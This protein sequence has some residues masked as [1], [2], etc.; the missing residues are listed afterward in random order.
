MMRIRKN[1]LDMT[2]H[3]WDVFNNAINE[4]VESGKW[5]AI[6]MYHADRVHGH[7]MYGS[8]AGP[9]GYDRFLHWHRAYL[10]ECEDALREIDPAITIPYWEWLASERIPPGLNHIP[11]RGVSHNPGIVNFTDQRE[12]SRIMRQATF[13]LFVRDLENNPH[14]L[15]HNW[16]G[17]IMSHPFD[18]PMDPL[19]FMHHAYIDKLFADWQ[20]RPGNMRKTPRIKGDDA[21]LDP[22]EEKWT[23]QNIHDIRELPQSYQYKYQELEVGRGRIIDERL[24]DLFRNIDRFR[25][26]ANH[27]PISSL[28]PRPNPLPFPLPPPQPDSAPDV[29]GKLSAEEIR[30]V[31]LLRTR[32]SNP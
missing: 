31:Q 19:F 7:R 29:L 30:L 12:I 23:V 28:N 24:T 10:L 3:D 13:D 21:K 15:G 18:S 11:L 22:W 27:V 1:M 25:S 20:A 14:N 5:N 16:V 6:S 17:G 4:L 26:P 32:N 9:V 2:Q 8:I